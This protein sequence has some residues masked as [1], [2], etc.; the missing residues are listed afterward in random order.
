MCS[1]PN[2]TEEANFQASQAMTQTL[3]SDYNQAFAQN[4]NILGSLTTALNQQIAKPQGF[5]SGQMAALRTGAMDTTTQQ[6]NAAKANAGAAAARYGGDVASGVTG[7]VIAGV[8]A[9]EA[10]A[11]SQEQN[12]ITEQNAELQ[13]QN[14]WRGIS[15]LQ[16]TAA[17]YNPTGYAGAGVAS[18]NA[19]TNAAGQVLAEQQAGWENTMGVIKGIG[20]LAS[21]A[22][23]LVGAGLNNLDTTGSSSFGEQVG[24]F[25]SGMANG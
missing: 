15:G 22:A 20:G 5:T 1:E 9:A 2:A 18:S 13:Q 7:Q 3:Q 24:N 6:F 8:G 16:N 25:F 21:A 23:P 14:Y 17:Q 4:Q 10:G 11:L 12:Q 19:T